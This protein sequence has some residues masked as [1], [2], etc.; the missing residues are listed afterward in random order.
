MTAVT[1]VVRGKSTGASS[2]TQ[3]LTRADFADILT[4]QCSLPV[5]TIVAII[6]NLPFLDLCDRTTT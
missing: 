5:L 4:L 2:S 6:N 3:T 1:G